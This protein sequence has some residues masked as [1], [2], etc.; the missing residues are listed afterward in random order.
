[1]EVS[2]QFH[3]PVALNRG[4]DPSYSLDRRLSE[5]QIRSGRCRGEK[6]VL[7]V[8]ENESVK[9]RIHFPSARPLQKLILYP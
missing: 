4:K 3:A 2:Y 5:F 9:L 1:M 7:P 8:P 6:N